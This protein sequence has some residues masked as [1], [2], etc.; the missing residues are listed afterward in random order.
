MNEPLLIWRFGR[1]IAQRQPGKARLWWSDGELTLYLRDGHI[2]GAEGPDPDFL[3]VILGSEGGEDRNL[4]ARAHAI[5]AQRNI[6]ETEAVARVKELIQKDLAAW[7]SDP[8]RGLEIADELPDP[9][10][11]HC[12]SATHAVVELVLSDPEGTLTQCILP[13]LE[14]LLR[15]SEGFLDL[16]APLRLSEDADL[17]VAKITGQRTANEITSRSPHAEEE[18]LPLLA[19]LTAAGMLEAI[20]V[21]VPSGELDLTADH[22]PQISLEDLPPIRRLSPFMLLGGA[23]ILAV[24]AVFFWWF[25]LREEP[26]PAVADEIGHWGIVVDLGCEPHEYR[27]LLELTRRFDDVRAIAVSDADQETGDCWRLVW[28]D[29]STSKQADD[30]VSTIPDRVLREGFEPHSV[31]IPEDLEELP[32]GS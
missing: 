29:F 7:M 17:I 3:D 16:Y 22:E 30:A 13:D 10:D 20:P 25:L 1:W 6:P 8:E 32:S 11:G 31:E 12:I 19:A 27:R 26:S 24:I 9:C 4:V 14:V 18:V 15:R 2:V 5:A 28:G 21:V 23:V